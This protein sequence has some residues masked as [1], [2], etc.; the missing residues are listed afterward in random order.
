MT[1]EKLIEAY[2]NQSKVVELKEE[3]Q[4]LFDIQNNNHPIKEANR[5]LEGE[6]KSWLNPDWARRFE[7]MIRACIDKRI[8]EINADI[9]KLEKEFETI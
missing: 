6:V 4:T 1:H 9:D 3:R 8:E 5:L 7:D 2:E